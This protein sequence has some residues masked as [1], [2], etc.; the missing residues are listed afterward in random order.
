MLQKKCSTEK[1]YKLDFD[2]ECNK[3]S[4]LFIHRLGDSNQYSLQFG[5]CSLI[6]KTTKKK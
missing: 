6:D 1:K 2:T 4:D 3:R 5:G